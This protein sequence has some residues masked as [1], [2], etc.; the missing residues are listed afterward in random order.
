MAEMIA[1]KIL[2]GEQ[3]LALEQGTFAGAPI[4]I[5]DGYIHLS[6]TAQV[7]ETVAK[8][9]VGQSDLSI[10]AVDLEALGETVRWEVSRGNQLFPHI[11]GPLTLDAVIAYGLIEYEGDGT[12]RLPVAG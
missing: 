10:A 9:F 7:D 8:H 4:D 12:I 3:M 2:T 1:Y 11:Y 5:Q 6:T